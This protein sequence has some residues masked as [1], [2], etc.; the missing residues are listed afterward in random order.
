MVRYFGG[1]FSY[2]L[3]ILC[4]GPPFE[5]CSIDSSQSP[6]S[7]FLLL[8]RNNKREK[9]QDDEDVPRSVPRHVFEKLSE[10]SEL[11]NSGALRQP[12]G[13]AM[14]NVQSRKSQS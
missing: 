8:R 11:S 4:F 12:N 14:R 5:K 9:A 10:R 2:S 7:G 6:S 13:G 3:E 1:S